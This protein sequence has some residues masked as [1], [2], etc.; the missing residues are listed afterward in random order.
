LLDVAA[1]HGDDQRLFPLLGERVRVRAVVTPSARSVHVGEE[2]FHA[3]EAG[4]EGE[5]LRHGILGKNSTFNIQHSTFNAQLPT[6]N[7][8][9]RAQPWRLSVEC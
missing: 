2:Q 1:R 6:L 3:A 4:G 9:R 5:G 7:A 8:A